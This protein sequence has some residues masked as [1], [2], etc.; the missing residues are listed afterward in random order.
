MT[1]MSKAVLPGTANVD[2]PKKSK[3]KR[4]KLIFPIFSD[5]KK[6]YNLDKRILVESSHDY[7]D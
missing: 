3:K 6:I 5:K 2:Y 7:H 1:I 4:S